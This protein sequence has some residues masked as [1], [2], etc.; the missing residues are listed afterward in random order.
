MASA[1]PGILAKKIASAPVVAPTPLANYNFNN[2]SIYSPT[3][4]DTYGGPP[5]S[6]NQP[7]NNTFYSGSSTNKYLYLWVPYGGTFQTGGL[8]LPYTVGVRTIEVWVNLPVLNMFG[9][10]LMDARSGAA[11][12]YWISGDYVAIGSDFTNGKIYIN[13]VGYAID[14]SRGEPNVGATI[15]SR[16]W[17]Q[18]V[19][20]TDIVFS[21]DIALYMS[22]GGSQGTPINIADV[23][24]YNTPLTSAQV[25]ASYNAKCSR[26]GL[27]AIP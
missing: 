1:L 3:L 15:A 17:Q 24:I 9:Q 21:D 6:I 16:G 8:L 10:Y 13:T 2:Y 23:S 20:V 26:Y 22:N 7:Y 14:P 5:C 11:N 27:S 19:I 12:G 18:L 4:S 25:K